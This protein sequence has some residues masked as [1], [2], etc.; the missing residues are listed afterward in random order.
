MYS[1]AGVLEIASCCLWKLSAELCARSVGRCMRKSRQD[2]GIPGSWDMSGE[3]GDG[4]WVLSDRSAIENVSLVNS[5]AAGD[6]NAEQVFVT[7]F[8]PRVRAMLQA[9]TRNSD[10]VADLLQDV[11]IESICA[12]RRGQ[13]REPSK[14]T[15][16]V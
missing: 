12:L 14:L 7:R 2:F 6:R 5:I 11:L 1:R 13:L 8:Q 4:S 15:A 9:R 10:H 3:T 16:F